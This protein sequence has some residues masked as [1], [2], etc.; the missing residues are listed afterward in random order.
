M[1]RAALP[2]VEKLRRQTKGRSEL[3]GNR[4]IPHPKASCVIK[5]RKDQTN[6]N[7]PRE[8]NVPF[9]REAKTH[10]S[11]AWPWKCRSQVFPQMRQAAWGSWGIPRLLLGIFFLRVPRHSESSQKLP[12]T[13]TKQKVKLRLYCLEENAVCP[14]FPQERIRRK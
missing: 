11:P 6:V 14:K 1:E 9:S 3:H 10:T 5:G 4:E 12:G 7:R 2:Q 13:E 8:T